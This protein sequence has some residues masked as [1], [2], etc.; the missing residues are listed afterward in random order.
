MAAI[1]LAT[2]VVLLAVGNLAA[3][4]VI[5]N[6]ISEA[7]SKKLGYDVDVTP[8]GPL[9]LVAVVKKHVDTVKVSSDN[10]KIGNFDNA[11]MH[12]RLNDVA[13][14]GGTTT[15]GSTQAEIE[16]PASAIAQQVGQGQVQVAGVRPDPTTNTLTLQMGPGGVA[17]VNL[18]PK[19][20]AGHLTFALEGV[21]IFGRP[22]P[23]QYR[24]KIEDRLPDSSNQKAYPLDMS[25]KTAQMTDSGVRVTLQGNSTEFKRS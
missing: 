4:T 14:G 23:D 24:Q 12:I 13:F 5:E 3:R 21:N 2:V 17:E 9:S 6:R 18:K 25:M 10:A 16:I 19:I 1:A 20:D 7:I 22:A 15:I 8:G 11:D